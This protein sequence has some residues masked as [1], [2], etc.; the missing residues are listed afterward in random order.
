MK[1]HNISEKELL[2]R[3]KISETMKGV[4]KSDETREKMRNAHIGM[5]YSD[6]TKRKLSDRVKKIYKIYKELNNNK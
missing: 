5:K 3:K 4:K 2:R 6:E 1:T